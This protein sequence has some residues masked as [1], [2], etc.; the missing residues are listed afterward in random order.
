MKEKIETAISLLG[1]IKEGIDHEHEEA[2]ECV[3]SIIE[4][5]DELEFMMEDKKC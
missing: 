3:N 4:L 1:A 5:L 2:Y